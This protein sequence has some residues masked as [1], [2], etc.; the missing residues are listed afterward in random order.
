MELAGSNLFIEA[1]VSIAYKVTSV[2][3]HMHEFNRMTIILI[4][5]LVMWDC[6]EQLLETSSLILDLRYGSIHRYYYTHLHYQTAD[7][8]RWV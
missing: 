7:K 2:N 1:K 3:T 4:V 6:R 8:I 5:S